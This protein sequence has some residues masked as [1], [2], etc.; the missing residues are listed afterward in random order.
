MYRARWRKSRGTGC[1]AGG[2]TIA[3]LFPILSS[4]RSRLSFLYY[5]KTS[6]TPETSSATG[7]AAPVPTGAPHRPPRLDSVDMLRGI[8][9]VIMALD[10]VRDY[11]SG[12]AF[13]PL[14]LAET[15]PGLFFTRW[16]THFCAPVFVFLTGT[17]AFLSGNRGK[18]TAELSW[19]LLTRGFWLVV[20]ELTVIRLGWQFNV[21]FRI[22]TIG[23]SMVALAGLVYLPK[24]VIAVFGIAMILVHNAF[25]Q[26]PPETFGSFWWIWNIL[27]VPHQIPLSEN[28]L[29]NP[30]YSLIPW[31]GVMACGY[32]FGSILQ[33]DPVRRKR[34]LLALGSGLALGFV[35]LRA[36]NVYGDPV[37]W[38]PQPD[39]LF[40]FLS[41]INTEKYPASL[42]FLLMT[43]GPAIATLPFLEKPPGKVGRFFI[44]FGRVPL[45]YYILHLYLIHALAVIGGMVQDFPARRMLVGHWAF[46]K[47]YGF[48]LPVVYGVWV[49]VVALLYPVCAWFARVK[50]RT[51]SGWLSYL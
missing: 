16:I 35:L 46:P 3:L 5:S 40:T 47:K 39:P 11:F 33:F 27:H 41:F 25:D 13:D 21:N 37:A 36:A 29:F 42:L 22:W 45:F 31:I 32:A 28:S 10:H 49:T 12:A 48:D 38:S 30:H 50:Q 4:F 8:V 6:M 26:I 44:V 20:L 43:L 9:M 1:D 14:D 17:G 19:F 34:A 51:K 7:I 15:D 2:L 18:S 23:W 24:R